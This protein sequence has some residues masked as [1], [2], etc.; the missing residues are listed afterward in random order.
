MLN[1]V[2]S[3]SCEVKHGGHRRRYNDQRVARR[4]ASSTQLDVRHTLTIVTNPPSIT[5]S[6][7]QPVWPSGKALGW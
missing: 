6:D 2:R 3:S 1:A 4:N 5:A 7:C